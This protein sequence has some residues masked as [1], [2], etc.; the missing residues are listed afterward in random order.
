M[1]ML[2]IVL[3]VLFVIVI[4]LANFLWA[5][6]AR[7]KNADSNKIEMG[8]DTSPGANDCAHEAGRT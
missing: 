5:K 8:L 2:K 4:F 1:E 6:L 7:T 3:A